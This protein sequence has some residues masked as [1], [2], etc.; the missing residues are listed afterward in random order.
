MTD[1]PTEPP[2]RRPLLTVEDLTVDLLPRG[3]AQRVVDGVSFTLHEEETLALIGESGSGKSITAMAVMGLLPATTARVG[4]R[5]LHR[6]TELLTLGPEA[7]RALRGKHL[8]MVFQDALSALNPS[9]TVGYQIAETLRAHEDIGRRE[10]RARALDLMARVRIPDPA[11][12]YRDHPHRFSGGMRQRVMIAMAVALRPSVLIADEPTT[13]LD[14]TVQAQI[15]ELLAE[16]REETRSALLLIT[17]DLGLAAGTADRVAIMYAGRIVEQAPVEE[18]YEHPS[19]PYTR[20]LLD[21][22]PRLDAG[23]DALT[24]I[25]GTPP[26]AG[27]LPDGCAFHP[28]CPGARPRCRGERPLLLAA[29]PGRSL[30]CHYP[31]ET[32]HA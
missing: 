25:P 15:M 5:V 21:A 9:L 27:H 23:T 16:L 32:A 18:L 30:A 4:G 24:P 26:A 17:H 14:V 12:R 1:H 6:D 13:A 20:G 11:R 7:L 31:L 8:A 22:V 3:A 10:A 28:R 19:H 2:A 29:P